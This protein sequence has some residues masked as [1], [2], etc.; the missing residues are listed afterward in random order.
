MLCGECFL[1][2]SKGGNEEVDLLDALALCL[3]AAERQRELL[4]RLLK[5]LRA[6]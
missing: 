4:D 3:E 2:R 1:V 6:R 5:G